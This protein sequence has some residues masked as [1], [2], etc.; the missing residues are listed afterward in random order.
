MNFQI[1]LDMIL[2]LI[3]SKDLCLLNDELIEICVEYTS[4]LGV[5]YRV[6]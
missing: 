4:I 1:T 3:L 2:Y 5:F 6:P